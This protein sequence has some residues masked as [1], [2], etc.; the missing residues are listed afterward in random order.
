MREHPA[1]WNVYDSLGEALEKSGDKKLAV[2]NY[3]KA[4]K[5]SP[6]DQ[7]KRIE[8]MLRKLGS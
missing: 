5:M 7:H 1:S 8:G 3:Q 4:L 6:N 2:E